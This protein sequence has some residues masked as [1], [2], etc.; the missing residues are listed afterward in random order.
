MSQQQ[1]TEFR[2]T[3][4]ERL[5]AIRLR[6][7][8]SQEELAAHESLTGHPTLKELFQFDL[9]WGW[10]AYSD[11]FVL[12]GTVSRHLNENEWRTFFRALRIDEYKKLFENHRRNI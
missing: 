11:Y 8:W 7:G 3:F 1:N 6:R 5:K 12:D 4:S 9:V 2:R 10:G